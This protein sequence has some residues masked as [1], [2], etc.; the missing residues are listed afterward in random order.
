MNGSDDLET[1]P[2]NLDDCNKADALIDVINRSRM[3]IGPIGCWS[4]SLQATVDVPPP[5]F[6]G[7]RTARS[8][9]GPGRPIQRSAGS[10]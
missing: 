7:A 6:G 5:L 9:P 1:G 4:W 10:G 3:H 8:R 2:L